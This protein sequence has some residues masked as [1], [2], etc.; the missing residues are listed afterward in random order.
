MAREDRRCRHESANASLDTTSALA[1]IVRGASAPDCAG[2]LR[3]GLD[4]VERPLAT[5]W[6]EVASTA[7]VLGR[8]L[9]V[10]RVVVGDVMFCV[11]PSS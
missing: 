5:G 11:F 1:R 6:C 8:E 9:L 2:G 10:A 4:S 3:G 7:A